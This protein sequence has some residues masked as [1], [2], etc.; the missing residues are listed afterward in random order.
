LIALAVTFLLSLVWFLYVWWLYPVR[1]QG[2]RRLLSACG[3]ARPF[4]HLKWFPFDADP[5]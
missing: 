1:L 5:I 2:L 3:I 4:D